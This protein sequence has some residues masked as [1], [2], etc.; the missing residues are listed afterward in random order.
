MDV[1]VSLPDAGVAAPL[2]P[3]LDGPV[4][5]P[6]KPSLAGLTRSELSAIL[7]DLGLPDR[8]IKMRVAQ[9]WH[10]IYFQGVTRFDAMLNIGKPLRAM[11]ADR[12]TLGAPGG[13][14][15]TGLGRRNPQVADP[16]AVD[17]C[18]TTAAPR[19]NAST[20]PNRTAARSASRARSA[21][22]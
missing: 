21:A 10:W 16:H 3:V 4:V 19:S 18:R 22:R 17:R 5:P 9:L 12:Y 13:R 20:S 6:A 7:R 15:R 14:G 11:L 2:A 1:S 8:E